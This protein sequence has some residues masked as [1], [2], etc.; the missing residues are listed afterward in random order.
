MNCRACQMCFVVLLVAWSPRAIAAPLIVDHTAVNLCTNLSAADIARVKQL[1]VS[2]AGE[3]HSAGVRIGCQ[4]LTNADSRLSVAIRESGTPDGATTNHLR[5]SRAT[6]GD[7]THTNSWVYS[8]G[9][10]DWY[11][12]AEAVA[13]TKK[14]LTFCA[15]NGP[16]LDVIGFGW[17]WDM[18]WHNDVGGGTNTTYGTRWAGSSVGGPDGD[19]RWGLTTADDPLTSN[20]VCL[21]T[22]LDATEQYRSHCA[23][24]GCPTVVIF[25][26]GPVDSVSGNERSYQL[27]V[28][29]QYIRDYVATTAD[30]ILFDYADILCWDNAGVQTTKTWVNHHGVLQTFPAIATDNMLDLDGTYVEDGDHIGQR[31]AL[32]LAKALWWM[33]AAMTEPPPPVAVSRVD[34]AFVLRFQGVSGKPYPLE[35]CDDLVSTNWQVLGTFSAGEDGVC[36]LT[37][38][39]PPGVTRRFYRVVCH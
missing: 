28:K 13:Q 17:C 33:L 4:L 21:D 19:L 12:S 16:Q 15:T 11:T 37:N 31:G 36:Q 20:R 9:E 25:T 2:Y 38:T 35:Y 29:N 32:R 39:P 3:S 14:G 8:Y 18:S 22:Y 5:L 26:T 6:R 1:W 30:G 24:N 27:Q 10:E 7:L 34:D 23:T